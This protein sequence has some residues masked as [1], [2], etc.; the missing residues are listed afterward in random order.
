MEH[1]RH[2]KKKLVFHGHMIQKIEKL[3]AIFT[4]IK[5][6]F[7]AYMCDRMQPYISRARKVVKNIFKAAAIGNMVPF[8][9][10]GPLNILMNLAMCLFL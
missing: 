6:G 9:H 4:S 5:Y 1:I 3:C 7:T 8:W 10:G 2:V